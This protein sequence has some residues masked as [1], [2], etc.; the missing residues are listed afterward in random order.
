V[1]LIALL[2]DHLLFSAALATALRAR[3][4]EV[5]TPP[6]SS[7][8]GLRTE[9]E[10]SRP[11]VVLLDRDLG[12]L[13]SG[14]E[15]IAWASRAGSSVV[16]VSANLDDIVVGRCLAL[17]AIA[18]MPKSEP[19][20]SLLATLTSIADGDSVFCNTERSRLITGWRRWQTASTAAAAPFGQLTPR[21]A[22]VLKCLMDGKPVR[23][24]A[25]DSYVTEATV[26]TQVRGILMKL[27]VNSQL[28]AVGLALRAGWRP[29]ANRGQPACSPSCSS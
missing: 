27:E 14:E 4:F 12:T 7:L 2:D 1:T 3:G 13:G 5:L 28:E 29:S 22:S 8:Q 18:C 15:L 20:E 26:R 19:F 21:E 24:I 10:T 9:L 23:A 16:V 17:G 11:D 25:R 6:L